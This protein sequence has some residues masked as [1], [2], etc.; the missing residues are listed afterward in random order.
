MGVCPF[1]EEVFP[2]PLIPKLPPSASLPKVESIGS[3]NEE[4]NE[5]GWASDHSPW[6]C[7]MRS[8][9]KVSEA[10]R[11]ERRGARKYSQWLEVGGGYMYMCDHEIVNGV[12]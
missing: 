5:S 2:A 11:K 9:N 12:N 1:A 7:A 10:T 4:R 6:L 8:P 3:F